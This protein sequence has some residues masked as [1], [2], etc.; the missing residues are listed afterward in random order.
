[1]I[2]TGKN[3][4]KLKPQGV[5]AAENVKAKIGFHGLVWKSKKTKQGKRSEL[6][7]CEGYSLLTHPYP[8]LYLAMN[9]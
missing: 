2:L 7:S 3:G 5:A 6:G 8:H 4:G 9:P 1:M